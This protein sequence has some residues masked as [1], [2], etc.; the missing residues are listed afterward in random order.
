[1]LQVLEVY[2]VDQLCDPFLYILI[3][4]GF[5]E[6]FQPGND[7]F[8]IM[9]QLIGHGIIDLIVG[10][11]YEAEK[12]FYF[13]AG[14]QFKGGFYNANLQNSPALNLSESLICC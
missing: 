4:G 10:V 11:V 14:L 7:L 13:A 5:P 3:C 2:A 12:G 1:M 9:Q 6:V 8:A